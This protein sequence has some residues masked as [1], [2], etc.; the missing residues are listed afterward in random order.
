MDRHG[1]PFTLTTHASIRSGRKPYCELSSCFA[2]PGIP[3]TPFEADE[4]PA[5]ATDPRPRTRGAWT[6]AVREGAVTESSHFPG[7]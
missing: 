5:P 3:R 6:T 7:K 1:F 4:P 2:P